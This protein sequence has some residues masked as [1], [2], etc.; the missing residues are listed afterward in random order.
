LALGFVL[1]GIF[2]LLKP[3][4]V[5]KALTGR[6]VRYGGGAMVMIV[7]FLGILILLNFISSRHHLRIDLTELKEFSLSPQTLQVLAELDEKVRITGFFIEDDPF[8]RQ[9]EFEDLLKEYLYHSDKLSYEAIDP[10]REPA[11]AKEFGRVPY[12]GL[13]IQRGDR[14]QSVYTPDEQEITSAILKVSR[15]KAKVIYFLTGH[16]ERDIEGFDPSGYSQIKRALERNNYEV[17]TLNLAITSTVPSD[18]SILVIASPKA[19]LLE[20]ERNAILSYL[21]KAGKA[22]I[23]QD[24]G[25]D[26]G[27]NELLSAWFVR[28]E[29][30]VLIDPLNSL[31]GD[32]ASPVSVRYPYSQITKDLPMTFFP[33]ARSVAFKEEKLSSIPG[34]PDFKPLIQ[35]SERSWGETDFQSKEVKYEEGEDARGPLAIA[36]TLECMATLSSEEMEEAESTKTRLVLFGDS[37]FASNAFVGSVGNGAL[38]LNAINWLAEEERLIAIEPKIPRPR[39]V[40]LTPS[41]ARLILYTSVGFLPLIV[42]ASGALVWWKRR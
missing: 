11:R 42:L 2:I 31:L 18:A 40:Y 7:S 15:E 33:R 8:S 4:E 1:I 24:P 39:T 32:L 26:A 13:L 20:D 3:E 37:D 30:D 19:P 38:F 10:D 14:R 27:L 41:Q 34:A 25:E 12:G 22:L 9:Q 17:K 21:M 36:A 23:M 16:G 28:F 35:T 6:T 5:M 29:D